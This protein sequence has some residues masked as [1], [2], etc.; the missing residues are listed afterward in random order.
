MPAA[1]HFA[2]PPDAP[3]P[4]SRYSQGA[5]VTGEGVRWL[6][7]SG[8]VA[9][10]PDGSVPPD[11]TAQI[12]LALANLLAV[13][14]G[15]GMGAGNVVKLTVFLTDPAL[16]GPW[17]IARDRVFADVPPPASTLLVVAGLA[18]PAFKVE[19]EAV[20]AA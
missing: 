7:A 3:T 17:R 13:L 11:G 2:N 8:Q 12:D 5:L 6:H 14:Q 20:A 16:I 19:V 9:V 4:A 1:L 18:S 10:A 15:F